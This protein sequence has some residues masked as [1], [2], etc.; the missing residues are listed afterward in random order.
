MLD[1]AKFYVEVQ[2]LIRA[3]LKVFHE[4]KSQFPYVSA[5]FSLMTAVEPGMPAL[6][7]AFLRFHF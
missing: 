4:G 3:E 6:I 1:V 2:S 5:V 7:P